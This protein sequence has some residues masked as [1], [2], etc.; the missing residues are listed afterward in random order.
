[1]TSLIDVSWEGGDYFIDLAGKHCLAPAP[2][3]GVENC[4]LYLVQQQVYYLK[5]HAP[6]HVRR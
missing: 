5:C 1:M 6:L 4:I 2:L 3:S